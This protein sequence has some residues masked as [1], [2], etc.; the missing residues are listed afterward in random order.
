M[1]P[2]PKYSKD[3]IID[4][5]V[6]IAAK[7]GISAITARE[8]AD[9]LS[10]S[11]RPIYSYFE[12]I[13]ELKREVIQRIMKNFTSELYKKR[14]DANQFLS[15]GLNLI[16]FVKNNKEYYGIIKHEGSK[17]IDFKAVNSFADIIVDKVSKSEEYS[18]FSKAK[19]KD[20][21]LKM[22]IFSHGLADFVYYGHIDGSESFIRKML[23]ETGKAIMKDV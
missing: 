12:S 19:I 6:Q 15:V 18:G 7:K 14:P 5:A 3:E 2:K 17:Y 8:L 16:S 4:M 13:D 1:P 23:E 9:K 21:Y 22:A 10:V 11:S 20:A